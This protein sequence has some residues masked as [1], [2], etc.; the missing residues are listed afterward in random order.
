V[1]W[2]VNFMVVKSLSERI[3]NAVDKKI[4]ETALKKVKSREKEFKLSF[5][6]KSKGR[7]AY[8][9]GKI[10]VFMLRTNRIVEPEWAYL[11]NGLINIGDKYFDGNQGFVYLWK[12]KIP[13]MIVPEWSLKPVG[14]KDYYDAVKEGNVSDSQGIMIRAFEAKEA[15]G[16][17]KVSMNTWIWIGL[18]GA[19]AAYALFAKG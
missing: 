11:N 7:M 15:E 14:T 5:I 19:I 10:L 18:L 17:K 4:N 9:R 12:S 3:N 1:E 16:V 6:T 13:V 2:G 8:K